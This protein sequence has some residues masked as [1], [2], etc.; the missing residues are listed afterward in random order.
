MGIN[1]PCCKKL[2]D[3]NTAAFEEEAQPKKGDVSIC[4]YCGNVLEFID[5]NNV[6]EVTSDI[7]ELWPI[8]TKREIQKV[9]E[10]IRAAISLN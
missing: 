5:A 1:C 2:L 4:A 8:E 6:K 3:A 7:I 9:Q 10:A